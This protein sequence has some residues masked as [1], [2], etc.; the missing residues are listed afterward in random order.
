[1]KNVQQEERAIAERGANA[2]AAAEGMPLPFPNIWDTLDPT[3]VDRTATPAQVHA[4]YL[5]F[6]M[7]CRPRPRIRHRL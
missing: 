1:V 6:A 5:R 2:R 4:S 3:K 7:L